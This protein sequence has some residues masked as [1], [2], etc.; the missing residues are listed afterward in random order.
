MQ[1]PFGAMWLNPETLNPV[2]LDP[3]PLCPFTERAGCTNLPRV[4]CKLWHV[5]WDSLLLKLGDAAVVMA[6]LGFARCVT[7]EYMS[8][9][10]TAF[11]DIKT[12]RGYSCIIFNQISR[13]PQACVRISGLAY[14]ETNMLQGTVAHVCIST[15]Q[16]CG[17]RAAS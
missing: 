3:Q 2:F 17:F 9:V 11:G 14:R 7:V 15:S 12:T 5:G 10:K 16:G 13:L 1:A 4:T 8:N 6:G